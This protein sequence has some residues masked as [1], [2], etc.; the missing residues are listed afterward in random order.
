MIEAERRLGRIERE[1]MWRQRLIALVD[2]IAR[3]LLVVG[4]L[5]AAILLYFR[6][7]A[8]LMPIWI[9]FAAIFS[10]AAAVSLA[11]WARR[12]ATGQDAAFLIDSRLKL[13]D[14]VATARAI[15][16]R[17][18]PFTTIEEALVLDAS[19]RVGD[20]AASRVLP[21]A[22][23][24]RHAL[25]LVGTLAL[26]TVFMIPQ[27]S[28]PVAREAAEA[29][30]DIETAGE[31]LESSALELQESIPTGAATSLLAKE[32]EDLGRSFRRAA[33]SRPEALR[34]LSALGERIRQ[35]RDELAS[36]RAPEIVELAQQRLQPALVSPAKK[37]GDSFSRPGRADGDT[38]LADASAAGASNRINA[39][40][41]PSGQPDET[42]AGANR[43]ASDV[44]APRRL[45]PGQPRAD[46][47][48]SSDGGKLK[49]KEEA[50]PPNGKPATREAS[51]S[52][53]R[54]PSNRA[55]SPTVQ[56]KADQAGAGDAVNAALKSASD[57]KR[58]AESTGASPPSQSAQNAQA[59]SPEA[60]S[61]QGAPSDANPPQLPATL[62]DLSK[63]LPDVVTDQ[64]IKALPKLS[65]Q[66]LDEAAKLRNHELTPDDIRQLQKGAE[67]LAKDLEKIAQSKELLQSVAQLA[68]Q[69]NS[70][71]LE[72][73]ARD[74]LSQ[75]KVRQE[76]ES[77]A[78]LLMEN[79]QA[80]DTIAGIG[81]QLKA[82]GNEM[83]ARGELNG[84]PRP[85]R[86]RSDQG[87]RRDQGRANGRNSRGLGGQV[88]TGSGPLP[89]PNGAGEKG[90]GRG[91][92]A[93][94]SGKL[95]RG[96]GGEY[97]YLPT[98][99]SGGAVRTP[100]SSVYPQYRREAER[101]VDRSQAPPRL[102]SV[103]RGYFD[104]INPESKKQ[105][106]N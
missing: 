23:K 70:E 32:Q 36:T 26:A 10:V 61:V 103:V 2:E 45:D 68:R 33:I 89:G 14:R 82:I 9:L 84:L 93:N 31:Q 48:P 56:G 13:E 18:G 96:N 66:L 102:R 39:K 35:R 58:A 92:E 59:R 43:S 25:G 37:R 22:I 76:L 30:A 71:Q 17:E 65:D 41:D 5:S 72:Q 90:S 52:G 27:R 75:E 63:A 20:V 74:L 6:L 7:R 83:A 29:R 21:F 42:L 57:E 98:K 34:K 38:P 19:M 106:S 105:P 15:L 100:Y 53:E 94:L 91:R 8:P 4:P 67:F 1:V 80:R 64:A 78:R 86:E 54:L 47:Q 51:S 73:V 62:P 104:A 88:T 77:A 79:Q 49:T 87:Q 40:H 44:A 81:R 50:E 16:V 28:S 11:R 95:Q 60:A 69:V 3:A 99:A 85:D 24:R 55:K 46:N 97:L 12:F 101:S